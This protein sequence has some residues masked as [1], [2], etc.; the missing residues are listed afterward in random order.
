MSSSQDTSQPNVLGDTQ[1]GVINMGFIACMA[2]LTCSEG[3][4]LE[5]PVPHR[6]GDDPL[7][8]ASWPHANIVVPSRGL[9][10]RTLSWGQ[11]IPKILARN[12][13]IQ[14]VKALLG[15]NSLSAH[16]PFLRKGHFKIRKGN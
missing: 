8:W 13:G 5:S 3:W 9:S 14:E 7:G 6:G 2:G 11:F 12:L 16:D 4:R 10:H 15:D 1:T